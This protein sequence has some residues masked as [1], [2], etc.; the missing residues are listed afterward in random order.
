[1]CSNDLYVTGTLVWYYYICPREVWL[2]ARKIAPDQDDA[3][4]DFG[5]FLQEKV[6]QRD[7]KEVSIGH[8]KI[9]VIKKERGRLVI[10]EV[11]K[12][13][14]YERSAK[15][16]LA[17]YLYE[18]KEA[19]VEAVGELMFPQE[20]KKKRIELNEELMQ[21]VVTTKKQILQLMYQEKPPEP[22][23]INFCKKCAYAE[24]CWA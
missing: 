1:M 2:M 17:F 19:G 23:K 20:K 16:Q 4:V 8:L 12:S 6:Y 9:D 21:E 5:R 11:K 15:M 3:N 13:S 24:L 10:G 7:K 22:Q 18:L 14:K